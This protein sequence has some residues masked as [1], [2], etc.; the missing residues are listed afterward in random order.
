[1]VGKLYVVILCMIIVIIIII[2]IKSL[3]NEVY[4]KIKIYYNI[5]SMLC[6]EL[7]SNQF[8]VSFYE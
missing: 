3:N 6:F 4:F 8:I 2:G 1:M 5:M 7:V